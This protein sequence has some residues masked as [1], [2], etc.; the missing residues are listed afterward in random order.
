[1]ATIKFYRSQTTPSNPQE[2]FVWFNSSNNTIQLYKNGAWEVYTGKINDVTYTDGVLTIT[3]HTG[4]PVSVNL[5]N[6]ANIEGLANRLSTLETSFSTLSGEFT[7][8]KEKIA[9]L[10][11]TVGTHTQAIA[12]VIGKLDGVQETVVKEIAKETTARE[13]ADSAFNT[14]VGVVEAGVAT[15]TGDITTLKGLVGD[16]AV[17]TQITNA[18]NALDNNGVT[19]TGSYVDVTVTQVDG[20][21]TTVAVA[22]GDLT[23]AFNDVNKTISDETTRATAKEGELEGAISTQ[24][25]RIDTLVGS[26]SGSIRDI[27]VDVLTETLVKEGAAEA[28]DTLQEVSEWIKNH[29]ESAATMNQSI[30][31]NTSAISGLTGKVENLEKIDHDAYKAADTA[32]ETKITTAYQAAD[33]ATLNSA[34]AYTDELSGKV[35]T[36]TTNI[37]TNT[38]A[39]ETINGQITQINTAIEENELTIASALTDLDNRVNALTE[40]TIKSVEGQNYVEVTTTDGAA[41]VKAT[42]GAVASGADGLALASDV[43][44]Y[45]DT[46]VASSWEW[47]SF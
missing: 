9:T 6:V 39:I 1:M 47:A 24:K 38:E 40:N 43:K 15:N 2:G 20:I 5:G 8:E 7:T 42:T 46:C 44:T 10:E 18:I 31:D 17:A 34:K 23:T 4:S 32:L 26:D 13:A 3:P 33:T 11:G 45:V 37:A 29:P 22:D 30:S 27:A 35:D 25:D 19:G 16:T 12:T 21:V 36:N 14:R 41:V 28:Y